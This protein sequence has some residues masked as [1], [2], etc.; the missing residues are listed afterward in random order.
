MKDKP[1][2]FST[3]MIRAIQKGIKTQTRRVIKQ[4]IIPEPARIEK[5]KEDI[6][7]PTSNGK[8]IFHPSQIKCPYRVGQIE[9][10]CFFDF[11]YEIGE[12]LC[13][14]KTE[15]IF[16]KVKDIRVER[17]QDIDEEDIIKEGIDVPRC[18]KCGY[19]LFDCK[20][21]MDHHLCNSIDPKSGKEAFINLWDSIYK[22]CGYGWSVNP[23]CW[24]VEFEKEVI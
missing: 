17:I 3:E 12:D 14:Y 16:L 13:F 11:D 4:K 7:L 9:T 1:I 5:Y 20:F 15:R 23:F 18:H 21:H 10:F 8:V 2:I 6:Y 19:T 24:V 22:K